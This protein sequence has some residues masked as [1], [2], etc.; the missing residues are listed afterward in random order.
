MQINV[1]ENRRTKAFF[2]DM[3]SR[4]RLLMISNIL[5][6]AKGKRRTRLHPCGGEMRANSARN[7]SLLEVE[8]DKNPAR[9]PFFAAAS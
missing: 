7:R 1:D 3:V 5:S 9:L 4:E 2:L 8:N 6:A